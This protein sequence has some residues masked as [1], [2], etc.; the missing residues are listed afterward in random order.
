MNLFAGRLRI[1]I[2]LASLGVLLYG[3]YTQRQ[4]LANALLALHHSQ[5]LL[6]L[7]C[8]LLAWTIY[9]WSGLSY[10][11]LTKRHIPLKLITLTHLAAAGPGRIIPGGGG[12]ISFGVL[13]LRKHRYSYQ[14]AIVVSTLHNFVGLAI[15]ALLV[16]LLIATG[17]IHPHLNVVSADILRNVALICAVIVCTVGIFA[18]AKLKTHLRTL[19][20]AY[21]NIVTDLRQHPTTS[22]KLVGCALA[23]IL[24]NALILY[25]AAKALDTPIAMAQAIFVTSTG[26]ALAGLIPTP[27]GVGGA[28]AGLLAGLYSFGYPLQA[29]AS[30]VA[31]YRAATYIQPLAPG[32]AAYVWLRHHKNI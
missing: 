24:T 19:G 4:V 9:A 21:Q 27:G 10:Y 14:Q 23:T 25:V 17:T 11:I 31:L 13:L 29:A 5:P 32:I 1:C 8:L 20:A 2:E 18:F 15:N 22:V 26:S 7:C 12:H 28:E 6:V 3:A 16:L 30:I